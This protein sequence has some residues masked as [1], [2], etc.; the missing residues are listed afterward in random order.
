MAETERRLLNHY[1]L[2]TLYPSEW[3]SRD[4]ESDASDD[5]RP[6]TAGSTSR[7]SALDRRASL[8]SSIPGTQRTRDG[9]DNLV[10]KDEPD[11]LGTSASVVQI[12]R[13]RGLPVEE[14][15]KL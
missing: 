7:F 10:Q 8:R 5:E 6:G 3:P 15:L 4:D 12:L 2:T 13:Q 11:P 9:A 1:K 14:N